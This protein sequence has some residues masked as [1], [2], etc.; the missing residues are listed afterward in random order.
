VLDAVA[1]TVADS[2]EG[3]HT[4]FKGHAALPETAGLVA[5]GRKHILEMNVDN[6]PA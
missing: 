4:G 5:A 3:A 1:A 2:F 6:V